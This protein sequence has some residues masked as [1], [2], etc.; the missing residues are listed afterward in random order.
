MHPTATRLATL[1]ILALSAL[2]GAAASPGAP[3]SL[4]GF[5][6]PE[7]V[8]VAGDRRFVSNIGAALNPTAKDG[9]GYISELDADGQV[10]AARAFP[11]EG[12][13]PLDAPK[14]MAMAG[15]RLYVADIDRV[16]GFDP[17]SHAQVFEAALPSAGPTLVNDLATVD[18]GHLL[19][20]ETLGGG[21][22]ELDLATGGF[23]RLTDATPGANGIAYDPATRSAIVVALGADFAGGDIYRVSLD[24]GANP[25][26]ASPH[27][28]F[29]GI[30]RRSDGRLV[31]SDWVSIEPPA[32][33]RFLTLEPDGSGPAAPLDLG[34]AITGPADFAIDQDGSLWIPATVENEIV[35]VPAGK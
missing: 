18:P 2:P 28:I 27:G 24:G 13:K 21:V 33:G 15:G 8:L 10:L 4:P 31:V 25:V 11:A 20:S 23:R 30:A 1:S 14:G 6:N 7:S 29:D 17:D 5:E 16:V 12:G 35:V 32:T 9:D 34:I 3:R 22:W 26:P 19:L